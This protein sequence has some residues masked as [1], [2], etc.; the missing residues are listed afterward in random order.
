MATSASGPSQTSAE[1]LS[2]SNAATNHYTT[3]EENL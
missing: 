2:L 1:E 3:T